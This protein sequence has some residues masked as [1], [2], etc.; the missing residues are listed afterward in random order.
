MLVLVAAWS[1]GP[2]RTPSSPGLDHRVEMVYNYRMTEPQIFIATK[3]LKPLVNVIISMTRRINREQNKEVN[4]IRAVMFTAGPVKLRATEAVEGVTQSTR[5]TV[6]RYQRGTFI[7]FL[8]E[9]QA[10]K[11]NFRRTCFVL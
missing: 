9:K 2:Q 11:S 6:M 5:N 1:P 8:E 7:L 4:T 10:P 3:L